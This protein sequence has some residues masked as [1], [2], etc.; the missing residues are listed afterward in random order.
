MIRSSLR[1]T[2]LVDVVGESLCGRFDETV[3]N[4]ISHFSGDS[5]DGRRFSE[6]RPS[7]DASVGMPQLNTDGR[8]TG[9]D[10]GCQ[11]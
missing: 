11:A 5:G 9:G 8:D 6:A 10:S 1:R 7:S 4:N 2:S 3:G